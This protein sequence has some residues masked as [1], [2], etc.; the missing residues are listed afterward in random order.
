MMGRERP[1]GDPGAID[2][3]R[4]GL[5][6]TA[7]DPPLDASLVAAARRGDR[8]AFATLVERHRHV[9]LSLARALLRN[10]HA[11]ADVVQEAAVTALVGLDSLRTGG[12]F[13][14]W[15]CGITLNLARRWSR[16]SR[17]AVDVWAPAN[18]LMDDPQE[19]A[20]RA[21]LAR[22]IRA[23]VARLPRAQREA[24]LAFY[25]RG[26]SH[27]EAAAEL[28]VSPGAVKARLHQARQS[29]SPHLSRL[30]EAQRTREETPM[31]SETP[32]DTGR[33]RPLAADMVRVDVAEVRRSRASGD[34]VA[35]HAVVLREQGGERE[36]P[37]YIGEA[38]AT[39]LA[40]SLE[41]VETPR[42]MTYALASQLVDAAGARVADVRVTRLS[43]RTIYAEVTV[44][45]PDG[46]HRVDARPSDALNLALVTGAPVLVE[47]AV[48]DELVGSALG[49][50]V[51]Y[52]DTAQQVVSDAVRRRSQVMELAEEARRHQREMGAERPSPSGAEPGPP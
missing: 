42:P 48:F 17:R 27:A 21:D 26:L 23:A 34:G 8:A 43:E 52:P 31:D 41:T 2:A 22:R 24:V 30:G 33:T 40:F 16:D 50:W 35:F 29:L 9:A 1:E 10:R 15:F 46:A 32:R 7:L 4:R 45:T 38:E 6:E 11:A 36:A 39:A 3:A 28:G 18:A 51:D 37:I 5:A 12:K 49:D 19:L 20:V 47:P 14:S 13:G 44:E 25:W